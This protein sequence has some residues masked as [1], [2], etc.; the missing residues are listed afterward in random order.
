MKLAII[1]HHIISI[2]SYCQ[3]YIY[4]YTTSSHLILSYISF[5]HR[6]DLTSRIFKSP[7]HIDSYYHHLTYIPSL[8]LQH[9]ISIHI[10]PFHIILSQLHNSSYKC[11]SFHFISSHLTFIF[12][13][14]YII[15][16]RYTLHSMSLLHVSKLIY[17]CTSFL[18]TSYQLSSLHIA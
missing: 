15:S 12:D 8:H 7:Y 3:L 10:L 17:I 18:N 1:S 14:T 16:H 11:I 6:W 4:Y 9:S 5:S 2:Y 13:S